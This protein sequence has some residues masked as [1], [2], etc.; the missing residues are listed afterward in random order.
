[1]DKAVVDLTPEEKDVLEE[2]EQKLKALEADPADLKQM[3]AKADE[4]TPA[5]QKFA[6]ARRNSVWG[7]L[8]SLKAKD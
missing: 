7:K 3:T 5:D 8:A 6:E 1:M 4:P 2:A